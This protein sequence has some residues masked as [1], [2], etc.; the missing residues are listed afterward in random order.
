MPK[1]E[2]NQGYRW[3]ANG[4]SGNKRVLK[5]KFDP[6]TIFGDNTMNI[7][8]M[9]FDTTVTGGAFG[10]STGEIAHV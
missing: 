5:V 1:A 8:F 10:N 6:N 4:R 7:T 2:Y 3:V 9:G